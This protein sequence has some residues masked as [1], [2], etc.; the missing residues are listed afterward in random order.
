MKLN[1]VIVA[2]IAIVVV[3]G[4][5]AGI[6]F[7]TQTAA[8]ENAEVKEVNIKIGLLFPLTGGLAPLGTDQYT[9]AKIALDLIN[10]RGGIAGK[11][12]IEY[13]TAD[14]ASDPTKAASEAERLITLE[15]VNIIVGSYASPL[16]LAASE[17]SE[18][19]KVVY[20]EV[21]AITDRATL[22]EFKY[23]LRNQPIGGD[24]GILSPVFV[25]E[26]VAPALGKKPSEI[27]VA[28]I[29]E[30]GPYGTSVA[31]GNRDTV[32]KLGL[33]LVLDEGYSAATTDLTGLILKLKTAEPDV[34]LHTG[35]FADVVLFIRQSQQ[36]GFKTKVLIGH[37]AGYGLPA[38][39][40]ELGAAFD[41]VFNLDPSSPYFNLESIAQELR[42]LNVEFV[43]RFRQARGYDPGT[44]GY[45]GF[46]NLL[47]L[48]T[49]ILPLAIEK[50]GSINA[51][52]IMKAAYELDI[53]EGGTLMGYGLKFAPPDSPKDTL[54]GEKYRDTKQLHIGQ[55]VRA[56]P[57]VLQWIGGQPEVVYPD[58]L[59]ARKP[60]IPL[61]KG[62]PLAP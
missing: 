32:R 20:Y 12:R 23:L 60:V 45:M 44:H 1:R 62:H 39:Y 10:E 38:T 40:E 61:P 24:F 19:Y 54:L 59:A 50:Y 57:V 43:K 21:G 11:Y 14:S 29:Y 33:N 34:V 17:I 49:N 31:A 16:L 56:Y 53:P 15:K 41:Y 35:Y 46:A 55:N 47:P 3:A 42:P 18:R 58:F 6:T 37:G 48:L 30:D 28:I 13:V 8:R 26:A 36:L 52:A 51:D 4:L 5:L 2:I 9:G 7:F 22:R 25:S 27:R